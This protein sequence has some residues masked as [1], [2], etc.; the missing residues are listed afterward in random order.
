M[1]Q[2]RNKKPTCGANMLCGSKENNSSNGLFLI[3]ALTLQQQCSSYGGVPGN[4]LC[5]RIIFVCLLGLA[6]IL[7]LVRWIQAFK[8]QVHL[9]PFLSYGRLSQMCW[10]RQSSTLVNVSSSNFLGSNMAVSTRSLISQMTSSLCAEA[11]KLCIGT[12]ILFGHRSHY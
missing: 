1:C 3:F 2:S 9:L 11:T 6:A 4:K 10:N 7:S 8:M 5:S 12:L